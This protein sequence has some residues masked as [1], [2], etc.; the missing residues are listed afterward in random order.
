MDTWYEQLESL[1]IHIASRDPKLKI[2]FDDVDASGFKLH[3]I[4][5]KP[6]PALIGAI[7]GQKIRYTQARKYRS[8]LYEVLGTDFTPEQVVDLDLTWLG[9]PHSMII[10]NV[11][12]YILEN[13]VDL[14]TESGIRS[15][16]NVKGVGQWTVNTTLLT[17]LMNWD[18]FP[19][20]DKF[21]QARIKKLYGSSK[22][23]SEITMKWSPY[24]SIVTWYLW[25]WF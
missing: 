6:Y 13:G 10:K 23:L 12:Q 18:I 17:C 24:R 5:K 21:L 20:N 4:I 9:N 11:T 1:K 19:E 7:I 22:N 15:L 8:K 25:R 2:V 3:E 14:S 16:E